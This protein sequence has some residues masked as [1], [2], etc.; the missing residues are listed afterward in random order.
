MGKKNLDLLPKKLRFGMLMLST[1]SLVL[2]I[3]ALSTGC[4]TS[5]DNPNSPSSNAKDLSS[6]QRARMKVDIANGA[7]L[8][9]DAT[10]ALQNLNEA[11]LEDD[12]LPEL[13]HTRA[14]AYFAKKDLDRAIKSAKI[15][16]DLKP[17]Y[18]DA[19]NTL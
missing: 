5:S 2:G 16:V 3:N 14:L 11:E 17:K 19:N 10:G 1:C 6:T 9:G 4:A 12:S 18:S 8:E 7:L 13:H 15:A